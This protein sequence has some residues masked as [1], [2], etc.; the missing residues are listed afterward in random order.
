[1]GGPGCACDDPAHR[2]AA[3]RE[4]GR[5]QVIVIFALSLIALMAVAG[6]AF[7]V[8]RFYSEKRY[9]QNAADAG[10]LAVAN[11]LIRGET[12]VAAEAE[13]RDVLARNLAG[14]PTGTPALV[15]TTPQYATGHPGDPVYLIS[16][17]LI[18]SGGDVRVAIKSD[19]TYTFG[20]VIGL[21]SAVVGGQAR[22]ATK[23][24]LLPI[25]VR[26]YVNAPGP[27]PG[28]LTPC[29]GN[30][31]QFQD[32]VST[33]ETSCL[34]S[35]SDPSPRSIPNPGAAFNPLTP[36][37]DPANHGPIIAIVGSG[38]SPSNA[39]SFRGFVT[40][41]I[42]NFYSQTPP[43]NLFYNGVT[44]ST[45]ANVLKDIEA[46]W[47]APGYPG[48]EFPP[49]VIPPDPDNQVGIIDGNSTG[50]IVDAVNVR[51][52]PGAEILTGVYSGIV[53]SI[54][55][56][57][58][59]VPTTV[60]INTNQNR[61]GAVT[62][63]VTKNNAFT[64][65]VATTAFGDWGDAASPYG[66][67]LLP[68]VFGPSPMTP[69]GF[70]TWTTFQTAGAP[71]GIYTVWIQ[72]HSSDPVL[73]DHYYPVGI[74]IGNVNRDFTTSSEATITLA[75]TGSTGT[76][77]ALVSTTNNNATFFG[78]NVD[79][80][81][82][83]GANAGGVL[84]VGIGAVSVSPSSVTLGKGVAQP[85]TIS[86]D[87]GTLSPG[88]Y[89][90]TM[91]AT[92]TNSAG[93]PVTRLMPVTLSIATASTSNQYVDIMGFATFRITAMDA[94]TVYGY[95]ISGVYADLNDPALRRG[96]VARLVPW[97]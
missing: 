45:G 75:T 81:I 63:Q 30:M 17:V 6:L 9:L 91:R 25:A 79:L 14:S 72:G 39:A 68:L 31:N 65:V 62:M 21:G 95:A 41:D 77:T 56:F 29:D 86:I 2:V 54:P 5:G 22:V 73:L 26:H 3:R 20:R 78:G 52:D 48:P 12:A 8:G 37:D 60:T 88:N 94:N 34:G 93:Q 40:L 82:E 7:D 13:G 23:G 35:V 15:A 33:A 58:Y 32:L 18:E 69:N 16:G 27:F 57:A 92:G 66:T 4:P 53:Q 10:A 11:A 84:P 80:S 51:Y 43:S 70:V 87:G 83:G 19:V 71:T 85:V 42:R 28:A 96:Q 36:E 55:D 38:A 97:N 47:V 49:A 59:T 74:A 1:M 44:V 46:A 67:T 64:G 89:S 61:D 76:A 24:D 50:A 90:L